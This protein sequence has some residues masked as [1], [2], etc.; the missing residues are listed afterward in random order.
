MNLSKQ[1]AKLTE[2]Q[3]LDGEQASDIKHELING[4]IYALV[5]ASAN[6]NRICATLTREFGNHL[7][8]TP[9]EVFT[10][11]MKVKVWQDFFYPDVMVVC[12]KH[13]NES[14]TDAPLLIVEVLSKS[15]R[16]TDRS[17]KKRV[18]QTL[19]S[20]HEY[21]M[22]EQD[23]VEIEICRRDDY[24]QSEHFF[25]GDDVVFTSIDLA[26]KVEDIY[27]RVINEDM[28]DYVNSLHRQ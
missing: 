14:F 2:Q 7:K 12:N 13:D 3:Y 4:S 15:T 9:C 16:K 10:S 22:I 17:L 21:I 8:N 1:H 20:L 26:L 25:L 28:A 18:Y 5:G 23:F 27:E 6:H 11:D 24:W 19:P